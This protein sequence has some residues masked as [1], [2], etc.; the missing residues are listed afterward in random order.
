MQK[1]KNK[2][3]GFSLL[4]FVKFRNNHEQQLGEP[5][6]LSRWSM[7]RLSDWNLPQNVLRHLPKHESEEFWDFIVGNSHLR[8]FFGKDNNIG[9]SQTQ[10]RRFRLK[11]TEHGQP[12]YGYR[13]IKLC[14]R[15]LS[16]HGS[17]Q[18]DTQFST[19]R[20]FVVPQLTSRV[21]NQVKLHR[22]SSSGWIR[23][24]L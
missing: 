13:W 6:E 22:Q 24:R 4:H 14:L 1:K 19:K 3:D 10:R 18:Q 11:V 16:V 23:N 2:A 17:V 21:V 12:P 5:Q 7:F 20:A 15:Q 9:R 8:D